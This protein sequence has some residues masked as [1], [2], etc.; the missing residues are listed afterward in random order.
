MQAMNTEQRLERI[1]RLLRDLSKPK[2]R[3]VRASVIVELTGWNGG[4]LRSGRESGAVVWKKEKDGTI[5]YDLNSI[6]PYLIKQP[7]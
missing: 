1:E 6:H 3:W 4:K 2:A 7:A 5:W